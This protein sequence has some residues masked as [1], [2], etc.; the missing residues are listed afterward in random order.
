MTYEVGHME[1]LYQNDSQQVCLCKAV[2]L[3][4][5]KKSIRFGTQTLEGV[6]RETGAA[7][8]ACKGTRCKEHILHIIDAYKKGEWQ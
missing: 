4:T 6:M 5:I 2:T 3:G 1:H 7:Q 8:G